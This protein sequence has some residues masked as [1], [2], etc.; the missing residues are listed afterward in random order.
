MKALIARANSPSSAFALFFA[1]LFVALLLIYGPI[2]GLVIIGAMTALA[3][4]I[5]APEIGAFVV[6]IAETAHR[7]RVRIIVGTACFTLGVLALLALGGAAHAAEAA[8]STASSPS[9][10][11]PWGDWLAGLL[12]TSGSIFLAVVSWGVKSFLP[13]YVRTFLT[14]DVIA[15]AV[16]Y[17]LASVEGAVRGKEA[18]IKVSNAVISAALEWIVDYEPKIQKWAGD[19]LEPLIIARLSA[20]N[21]IPATASASTLG[22]S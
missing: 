8:A 6:R 2:V 21:V 14:N 11:I 15:K 10:S 13:S 4:L 19:N 17:A 5:F 7:S 12:A 1:S 22:A 9:V 3:A 16:D 20:L 18:D